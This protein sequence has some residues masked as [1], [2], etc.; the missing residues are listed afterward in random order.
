MPDPAVSVVVVAHSERPELERCFESIGRWA[1]MPTQTVLVDNASTDDTLPWVRQHHPEVEVV[2]LDRNIGVAARQHGL[3]RAVAPLT[4]FL[5]SDAALTSGALPAMVEAFEQN[6]SWGLIGPRLVGDDGELQLSA[7][8]FPPR[9]L[10]LVRR[11]PWSRRLADSRIVQRHL[12]AD[13]DHDVVRPVLYVLGACQL[14]RTSLA[15][16]AGP[17]ADWMFL[18][19]DAADWCFR[20]RE[21]GGEIVYFPTATVVHSYRRRSKAAPVS[22]VA[23]RHL[24]AYALFQWKYRRKR[25]DLLRLQDEL[26]RRAAFPG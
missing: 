3:E 13:V 6:P 23:W 18:G 11:G 2:E 4:M 20:I 15:R 16:A 8:R 25:R 19:P 26:D 17:F 24:R 10:P 12:M 5:D 22:R 9:T 14:F 21:A 1:G 7:R